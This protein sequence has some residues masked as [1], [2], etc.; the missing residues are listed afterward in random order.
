MSETVSGVVEKINKNKGGFYGILIADTWFGGGKDTPNY[1][2]GDTVQFDWTPNGKFKNIQGNVEV[3][4]AGTGTSTP[5]KASGGS[6]KATNWDLK[7]K[8]IT[9]LACRKDAIALFG[10]F[11]EK[12]AITLPTKKADR[13]D[14]ILES[15]AKLTNELYSEVYSAPFEVE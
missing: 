4:E 15:V 1:N 13:V 10:I 2:E 12:D 7:D 11:V 9:H 6:G 8:R 14:I 3:V 5:A